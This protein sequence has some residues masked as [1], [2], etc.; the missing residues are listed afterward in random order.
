MEGSVNNPP[1][2]EIP[3]ELLKNIRNLIEITNS[4]IKWKTEEFLPVGAIVKQ[5]D[6][7]LQS[8]QAK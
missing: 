7:L 4:R 1:T 8:D 2:I 6:E 3:L 5:L